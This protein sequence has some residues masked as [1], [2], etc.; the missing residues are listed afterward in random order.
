MALVVSP[1]IREK[2]MHKHNVC[3]EEVSQCFANC[4]G[5]YLANIS[6]ILARVTPLTRPRYGLFQ[7]PIM[8][9][10]LRLFLSLGAKMFT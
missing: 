1:N 6:S 3:E 9:V 4:T 8:P 5:K 7:K 2:L 10:S